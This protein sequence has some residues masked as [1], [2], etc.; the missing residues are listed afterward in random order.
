MAENDTAKQLAELRA[1]LD[2]L[3]ATKPAAV[4]GLVLPAAAPK[5]T[6]RKVVLI[7]GEGAKDHLEVPIDSAPVLESM[8][9]VRKGR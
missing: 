9:W 4:P 6:S 8:G 5:D 7:P 1:E 3:K 2:A